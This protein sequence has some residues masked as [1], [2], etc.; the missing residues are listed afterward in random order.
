MTERVHPPLVP[1]RCCWRFSPRAKD[2]PV[3]SIVCWASGCA[4]RLP[5]DALGEPFAAAALDP[6]P[7]PWHVDNVPVAPC[8][9]DEVRS[10]DPV[11]V[12]LRCA[13]QLL[14]SR[15]IHTLSPMATR[16]LADALALVLEHCAEELEAT[17]TP[18][19]AGA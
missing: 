8:P 10:A 7:R 16:Q 15:D 14:R 12:E 6:R 1:V 18:D 2:A 19:K 17:A 5:L 11:T 13:A 9:F 3:D 4:T